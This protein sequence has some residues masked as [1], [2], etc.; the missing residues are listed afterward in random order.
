[1]SVLDRTHR[2]APHLIVDIIFSALA[3]VC[4]TANSIGL[5]IHSI[6]NFLPYTVPYLKISFEVVSSTCSSIVIERY[7]QGQILV[8]IRSRK[9]RDLQMVGIASHLYDVCCF[10]E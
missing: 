1:M 10:H 6:V 8:F 5:F 9:G 7:M 2:C 4:S 3:E